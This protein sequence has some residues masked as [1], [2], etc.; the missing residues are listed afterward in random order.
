MYFWSKYFFWLTFDTWSVER[1]RGKRRG[2]IGYIGMCPWTTF[3]IPRS[4]RWEGLMAVAVQPCK[5][6]WDVLQSNR[7]LTIVEQPETIVLIQ[8]SQVAPEN[9]RPTQIASQPC[10]TH[11][12]SVV[13]VRL[14]TGFFGNPTAEFRRLKE[15]MRFKTSRP[16]P[17]IKESPLL[18]VCA[19][20][21]WLPSHDVCFNSSATIYIDTIP[22]HLPC[23]KSKA[24]TI[25]WIHGS[26]R[27]EFGLEWTWRLADD[28]RNVAKAWQFWWRIAKRWKD[29]KHWEELRLLAQA[30]WQWPNDR[31]DIP[32]QYP[33]SMLVDW[34]LRGGVHKPTKV[35]H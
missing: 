27:R 21:D 13:R 12:A 32:G 31:E 23:S 7:C 16:V 30:V 9:I 1:K 34:K 14:W 19:I 25:W 24:Y 4:Y 2:C 6:G 15:S 18:R 26:I 3:A 10:I 29:T 5:K 11:A 22:P 35:A 8:S 20:N 17:R 28:D 33:W